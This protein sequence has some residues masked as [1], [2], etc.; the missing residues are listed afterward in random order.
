MQKTWKH[1]KNRGR[2]RPSNRCTACDGRGWRNRN[3]CTVCGGSGI[4]RRQQKAGYS[5]ETM[6]AMAQWPEA[7]FAK[8][9]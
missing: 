1:R 8:C 3:A 7:A 9:R 6:N 4:K 5:V 2:R